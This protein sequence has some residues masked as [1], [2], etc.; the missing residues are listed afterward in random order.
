MSSRALRRLQ[1]ERELENQSK[2]TQDADGDVDMDG[3]A[4]PQ[5]MARAN[6][7]NAFVMLEGMDAEESDEEDK[8]QDDQEA[9][10]KANS[11]QMV[12]EQMSTQPSKARKKKKKNKKK[13]KEKQNIP[14]HRSD[15][16][17]HDEIDQAL[18]ELG[19][20]NT[21]QLSQLSAGQNGQPARCLELLSIEPRYLNPANE[22]RSLF[23][24][25]VLE[26]SSNRRTHRPQRRREQNQQ[27]GVDLATA[28]TGRYSIAS[29]GRELG[30]LASRK[31]IFMQGKEEWPL[32]TSGGLSMECDSSTGKRQYNIIHNNTYQETQY[33]FKLAVDSMQPQNMVTLLAMHPYH[34]A[35]LLQVSEIAKHQGDHSV[36]GDLLERALFTFGRSVHSTFPAAVRGGT[37]LVPFGRSANRELYLTIWR[38]IKN[39]EMR[40][41]WRTAFEWSKV[42]YQLDPISDP[43]GITLMIDQ[44]AIRGRQHAA[45]I[46]LCAEEA[47]GRM[48]HHLPNIQISLALAYLKS[49]QP[50]LA[51]EHLAVA[52]H[53][54]P[55]VLSRLASVLEIE[56]LPSSLWGKLPS[57]EPEKLYTELYA[58][59][60][61]DLWNTPEATSLLVEVAETL[62]HYSHLLIHAAPPAPL[63]ISLEE[64]RHIILLE[65]PQL[66]GLLPR[67]FTNMATSSSDVLPP[68]D[69]SSDFVARAPH[70]A[71]GPSALQTLLNT[72]GTAT[73]TPITAVGG[74]LTRVMEWFQRPADPLEAT[75][76]EGETAMRELR[77]FVGDGVPTEVL[78]ELLQLQLDNEADEFVPD[79]PRWGHFDY[80]AE[81]AQRSSDAGESDDEDDGEEIPDL[82]S[83]P[84]EVHENPHAARVDEDDE[85]LSES[86]HYFPRLPTS[87]RA[88]LRHVDSDEEE[89]EEPQQARIRMEESPPPMFLRPNSPYNPPSRRRAQRQNN[90]APGALDSE[91]FNAGDPQRVQR[92]LLT[93]G[94]ERLKQDPSTIA[95]YTVKLHLLRRQQQEWVVNMVRQRD[96]KDLADRIARE[97]Q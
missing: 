25:I 86:E 83:I 10:V 2:V 32:A 93:S 68:P 35:S 52:M 65:I 96:E 17:Q 58:T 31:T 66:I 73:N 18:E 29:K 51:R 16:P 39:L 36:S 19:M 85:S 7:R 34:I 41:T 13:A 5:P 57:T 94:L 89:G 87:A 67:R 74:L 69:S 60:A 62:S 48:W 11:G 26:N 80:Y 91:V 27:G 53:Y 30:A 70:D 54:Y 22:M 75:D 81:G 44:L 79:D 59:R 95:D 97:V 40:G 56:P 4:D 14:R 78:Q 12:T 9:G 8:Q 71:S 77:E 55:Y 47:F 20:T 45:L 50:R 88:V 82:E 49:S 15:D 6:L 24:N 23:G 1:K 76:S 46:D 3:D 28:L 63:E 92:W 38:Y 37:A 42:L 64:A 84:D 43:F 21:A 33:Q 72:A 90:I 61:K